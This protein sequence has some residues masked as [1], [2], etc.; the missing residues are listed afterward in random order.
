VK[1]AV[2]TQSSSGHDEW[3]KISTK[4]CEIAWNNKDF[5][6]GWCKVSDLV[7]GE[8]RFKVRSS[9]KSTTATG[10]RNYPATG[11]SVE[12][13]STELNYRELVRNSLPIQ[14]NLVGKVILKIGD[15]SPIDDWEISVSNK[16]SMY[17]SF[18]FP[19][20]EDNWKTQ[21]FT[22]KIT[23]DIFRKK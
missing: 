3:V 14:N 1:K 19:P 12:N 4:T 20:T 5:K 11:I 6:D 17:A 23:I 22:G 9:L 16:D 2:D 7:S 10:D 21:E 15:E 13:L 8:Y 18:N